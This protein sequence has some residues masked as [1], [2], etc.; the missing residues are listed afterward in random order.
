VLVFSPSSA[1]VLYDNCEIRVVIVPCQISGF[2]AQLFLLSMNTT[3][4]LVHMTLL[5]TIRA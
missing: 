5:S 1:K 4:F 3:L 2:V